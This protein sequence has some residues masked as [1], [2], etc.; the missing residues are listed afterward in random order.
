[1]VRRRT[2]PPARL[3]TAP[4]RRVGRGRPSE[5]PP[6]PA[7][8]RASRPTRARRE[9][10][11]GSS[12]HAVG[13][14]F[15][16]LGRRPAAA[17][18]SRRQPPG[19]GH[20]T[21]ARQHRHPVG[22][23]RQ[24]GRPTTARR[25]RHPVGRTRQRGRPTT[26]RRL[27]HPVGRTRQRS[28]PTTARRLGHHAV[29]RARRG[30]HAVPSRRR[31][32]RGDTALGRHDRVRRGRGASVARRANALGRHQGIQRRRHDGNPVGRC[33]RRRERRMV[34]GRS[35]RHTVGRCR[36]G[37]TGRSPERE[38]RAAQRAQRRRAHRLVGW[39]ADQRRPAGER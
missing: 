2:R 32:E 24:R 28:R 15:D 10:V 38:R 12:G 23:T 35:R 27:G 13:R 4:Q 37:R 9:R 26:A 3:P 30:G 8:R 20:P 18:R 1:V 36:C 22:R 34:G 6:G 21:T 25:H 33:T 31:P 14:R 11:V 5:A 29:G 17:R 16:G 39:A 19:R 7:P